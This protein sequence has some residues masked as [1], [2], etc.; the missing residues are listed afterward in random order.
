MKRYIRS[1][2]A[3]Q[4]PNRTKIDKGDGHRFFVYYTNPDRLG[5]MRAQIQ[6]IHP[7][8]DADYAW[9]A[10]DGLQVKF[11]NRKG[12][13]DKMPLW[14]YEPDDYADDVMSYVDDVLDAICDELVKLN[15]NVKPVIVH[16]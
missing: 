16:D 10:V 5:T 7:Y 13:I 2:T 3:D 15:E 8:N 6:E 9:A 11:Y 1:T 12:L 14:S 4:F